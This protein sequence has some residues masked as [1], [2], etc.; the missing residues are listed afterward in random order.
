[1]LD[2]LTL[3]SLPTLHGERVI[4]RGPQDSDVDDRLRHPI[5]PEEEDGYGSAWR[6]EWDGRR[7]H[8]REHLIAASSPPAPRTYTWMVAY[9]GHCI[10]S[11]GLEVNPEQH[12]AEY[13]VGLFVAAVNCYLSCGFRQE[14][15]RRE[16]ELYPDGWKDFIM[17]GIL[18]SEYAMPVT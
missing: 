3:P 13:T 2:S 15:V 16:A 4:L 5:D 14:G 10:G 17:M 8:T 9:G 1:M 7:Y 12:S 6:R 18:R 11:A